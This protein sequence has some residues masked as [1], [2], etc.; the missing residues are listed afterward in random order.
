MKIA[1][2]ADGAIQNIDIDERS[3]GSQGKRCEF[4]CLETLCNEKL[5][6]VDITKLSS[7]VSS[8]PDVKCLHLFEILS[9][10]SSFCSYISSRGVKEGYEH[11][12]IAI[13]PDERGLTAD[14]THEVL[15]KKDHMVIRL[16]EREKPVLDENNLAESIDAVVTVKYNG[17]DR[18]REELKGS[19]FEAV[20]AQ[21]NRLFSKC[22][23]LEKEY[24]ELKGRYR[25]FNTPSMV[26]LFL[27]TMSHG[28]LKGRISR[29]LKIEKILHYL[30]T[31][32]GKNPCKG[33]GG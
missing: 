4:G 32:Y 5:A 29:A 17:E 19:G 31:G 33:F 6:G 24:Y 22:H 21:L 30:Q 18:L 7:I 1:L 25:F 15:G 8:A 23:H 3:K 14:T 16:D 13:R 26:G 2:N 12:Y 28:G 10:C 27:L 9:A 20:Y 11:E